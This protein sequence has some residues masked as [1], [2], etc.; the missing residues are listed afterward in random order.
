M[1]ARE[2][3]G[4]GHLA[5]ALN[6]SALY[7]GSALGAGAGGVWLS[8]GWPVWALAAG[9]GVIGFCGLEVCLPGKRKAADMPA[10]V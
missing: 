6:E 8:P 4:D 1:T 9:A 10:R 2:N 3:S 5:V 7:L